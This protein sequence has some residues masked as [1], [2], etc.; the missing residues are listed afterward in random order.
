MYQNRSQITAPSRE[1]EAEEAAQ[2]VGL[3]ALK[4]GDLSNQAGKDYVFDIDRFHLRLKEIQDRIF[5]IPSFV[6]NQF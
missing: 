1:A 2:K 5:C 4:Y 6:L 3:A